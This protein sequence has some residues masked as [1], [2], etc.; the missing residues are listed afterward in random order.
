MKRKRK[1]PKKSGLGSKPL[2]TLVLALISILLFSIGMKAVIN[3]DVQPVKP[4]KTYYKCDKCTPR[5]MCY[6]T[7]CVR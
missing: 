1:T 4:P 7:W 2:S 6:E 3:E 5:G